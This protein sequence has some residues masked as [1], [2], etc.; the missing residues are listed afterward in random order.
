MADLDQRVLDLANAVGADYK[1]I[2]DVVGLL[3]NLTTSDK[4][5]IVNAINSLVAKQGDLTTLTTAQKNNLVA[6]INELHTLVTSSSSINDAA[7]SN[8]TTYSSNKITADI[9][10]ARQTL[11]GGIPSTTFDTLKEIADYI[12]GDQ[13]ATSALTTAINNRVRHDAPQALSVAQKLQACQNIGIGDPDTNFLA[14]YN[15]AKA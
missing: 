3:A 9:E 2:N 4:T 1:A 13:T 7:A 8:S 11:L 14:A 5:S 6:A 12:A 10:A 15:L